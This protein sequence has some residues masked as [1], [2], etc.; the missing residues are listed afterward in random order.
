MKHL[1]V[2]NTLL[3]LALTGAASASFAATTSTLDLT[4]G[5]TISPAPCTLDF[6]AG[7]TVDFGTTKASALSKTAYY[8]LGILSTHANITCSAPIKAAFKIVDNRAASA[9]RDDGMNALISNFGQSYLFG[10]GQANSINIGAY[11]IYFTEAAVFDGTTQANNMLSTNGTAWTNN[12]N[13]WLDPSGKTFYSAGSG[14]TP[15]AGRNMSYQ[16]KVKAALNKAT[17]LNLVNDIQ[18]DGAATFELV[19]L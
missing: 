3:A 12:T 4:V 10:L 2:R 18:L 6:D 19:Y 15:A 11:G 14:T 5:G 1:N 7:N 16:I 8:N 9:I 17:A 13:T